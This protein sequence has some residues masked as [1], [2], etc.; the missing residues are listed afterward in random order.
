MAAPAEV[1]GRPAKRPAGDQAGPLAK[2]PRR[3]SKKKARLTI[4]NC[5]IQDPTKLPKYKQV[6]DV[7]KA[8]ADPGPITAEKL[9]EVFSN[10]RLKLRVDIRHGRARKH[11]RSLFVCNVTCGNDYLAKAQHWDKRVAISKAVQVAWDRFSGAPRFAALAKMVKEDS[12]YGANVLQKLHS[13]FVKCRLEVDHKYRTLGEGD[14]LKRAVHQ[15][16]VSCNAEV[17]GQETAGSKKE[18]KEASYKA[19]WNWLLSY[20]ESP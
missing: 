9:I 15:C 17:I 2:T 19:I 8:D 13:G 11:H 4:Q 18:A 16:I 12:L 14:K 1:A 10:C 3:C 7:I 6:A 20:P 5:F